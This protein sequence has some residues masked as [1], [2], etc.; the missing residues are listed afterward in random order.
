MRIIVFEDEAVARLYPMSLARPA[1]AITCGS[2]RLADLLTLLPGSKYG[3]VRPHLTE[4]QRIDFPDIQGDVPADAQPLLLVNA[5]LIPSLDNLHLLKKL[6]N[7]SE[8]VVVREGAEVAALRLPG[9]KGQLAAA[10]FASLNE[11]LR[12]PLV[13]DT[14]PLELDLKLFQYSHQVIHANQKILRENLELRLQSGAYREVADGVFL[15]EGARLSEHVSTN[16]KDG[17]ILLEANASV[18]PFCFLSGPGYV[19]RNSRLIE[20]AAIKDACSVSH[21]VKIGGEVEASIIEPYTNKQHYGFLGHSYLGSWINLGAGTCNSDL[22]NTY[23]S[24]NMD[25]PFGR[26][27]T[28]RQFVG[29]IMGD[30]AKTA[31]NTGI[32]TGKTIGVC[33][34]LYGFVTTNVPSFVNYARL[35]GQVTELPPDV[36]IATQQRMFHRRN[37][38]QRPCDIQLIHDMYELTRDDRQTSG[39]NLSL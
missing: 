2:F 15:A 30:Y 39:D 34:M 14:Q 33:S 25:Y 26:V 16:T 32:F 36:M 29:C 27:P 24:I 35:F 7:A 9:N 4:I 10:D 22:K 3:I 38:T 31:I 19:G 1:Y 17:P 28:G 37:V 8:P 23:G 6:S 18:G 20:H 11:F 12:C 5:R 13:A 21:T